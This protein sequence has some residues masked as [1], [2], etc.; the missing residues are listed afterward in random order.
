MEID[1]ALRRA[2]DGDP[3]AYGIVVRATQARLRSFIAGY[4][5][6]A[7]WIDEIAQQA[8]VSA[9][10]SLADFRPGTDFPAWLRQIAYNHL[11]AELEKASRR[12]RLEAACAAELSRRLER[13]AGRDDDA[14]GDLRDC[15]DALP[16]TSK[17]IVRRFYADADPLAA[18]AKSLG[19][20]A[21]GLKVT[22]F[23]IRAALR[24][25]IERRRSAAT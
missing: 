14:V 21:D 18:I 4:V 12:R 23:K 2:R 8:F 16:P 5:P 3:D 10:R 9:F 25:C 24:D 13:D 11:R 17:E 6:R 1:E 19:R 15:V 22:L 7:E 20:S